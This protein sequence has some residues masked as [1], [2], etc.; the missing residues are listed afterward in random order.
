VRRP[1]PRAGVPW[2]HGPYLLIARPTIYLRTLLGVSPVRGTL[3]VGFGTGLGLCV[4]GEC[5][6]LEAD[7][8]LLAEVRATAGW[9]TRYRFVNFSTRFQARPWSFGDFT[10]GASFGLVTRIGTATLT[11]TDTTRLATN[12]GVRGTLE[13]AW[14]FARRFELV[15]EAGVDLSLDR[16]KFIRTTGEVLLLED[17]WTPWIVTSVRLRP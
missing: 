6:V 2:R 7:L 15:L 9:E 17:R 10:P 12:L 1:R 13:I 4:G 5:V 8:P 14:K 11:E 3:L 16:A